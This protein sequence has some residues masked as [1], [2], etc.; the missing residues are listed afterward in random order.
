MRSSFSAETPAYPLCSLP[1]HDPQTIDLER[2]PTAPISVSIHSELRIDRID[3][4]LAVS[5]IVYQAGIA[6]N[7]Q[8]MGNP[9]LSQS[10][11]A[12]DIRYTMLSL[13]ENSQYLESGLITHGFD[14]AHWVLTCVLRFLYFR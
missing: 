9:G 8:V 2:R 3:D 10:Q 1:E 7:G 12:G 11:P 13:E 4:L 6:K 14:R 5:P